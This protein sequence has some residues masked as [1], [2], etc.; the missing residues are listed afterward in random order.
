[1]SAAYSAERQ[2]FLHDVFVTALEGGIGYWS[3]CTAYHWMVKGTDGVP[4]LEGFYA[5]IESDDPGETW[6]HRI[7]RTTI[8]RG[9]G[10]IRGG[11]VKLCDYLLRSI[12]AADVKNDACEIDAEGADCI[13]QAG[14]FGEVVYG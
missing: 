5:E 8:T 3:V 7:T 12:L 6:K 10:A 11:K 9:L 4:D 13:V 1:M 2:Q 14:L